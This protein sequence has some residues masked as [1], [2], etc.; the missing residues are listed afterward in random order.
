MVTKARRRTTQDGL[1][2]S[3]ENDP[4]AEKAAEIRELR[5]ARE[6]AESD[7]TATEADP[8]PSRGTGT[9]SRKRRASSGR[10][11]D[12]GS[13]RSTYPGTGR[14]KDLTKDLAAAIGKFTIPLMA[15]SVR[16][17]RYAYDARIVLENAEELAK[18]L[19]D[20]AQRN[21]SV[22][23]V[24]FY[25]TNAGDATELGTVAIGIAIPIMV[26][27]GILPKQAIGI[28]G[29][30]MPDHLKEE[31]QEREAQSQVTQP[32]RPVVQGE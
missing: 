19:N 31:E 9:S 12:T 29:A 14:R 1:P 20:L 7:D 17:K 30:P 26:N 27:H 2:D 22:Y 3:S 11:S 5:A 15:L 25:V 8:K 16:D 13:S 21:P 32:L 23:R 18:A 24:L 4:L 10:S 28:T 6:A